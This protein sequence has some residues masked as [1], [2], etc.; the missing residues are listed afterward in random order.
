MVK[1]AMI[2]AAGVGSRLDPLTKNTPKPLVPIA[3]RPVMDLLL[4]KLSKVGIKKVIANTHCLA[5]QIQER[6]TNKN[7]FGI[8]FNHIFEETLSGTAGGVKKCE[9]FFDKDETFIVMSADGLTSADIGKVI[10]SHKASGAIATIGLTEVPEKEVPNFGVVVTN[11]D[12]RIIEFQEKPSIKDAKS[13]LVNTGIYVFESKI[14]EYMPKDSFYDFAKNV[15]PDLMSKNIPINTCVIKEYWSDIGTINQY[16]M[17]TNDV[18]EG[19]LNVE[20]GYIQNESSRIAANALM[21]NAKVTNS[22][23]GSNTCIAGDNVVVQKSVLGKNC[24]IN[25]DVKLNNCI[26]WDNVTIEEN[27]HLENCIIANDVLIKKHSKI[28]EGSVIGAFQIIGNNL[29][30]Q[31]D[32]FIK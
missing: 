1:K 28:D 6:Y 17:S 9:F 10:Q 3:N 27:V 30:K 23:I 16:R 22:I 8:E 26:I 21:G 19:I 4:E 14:F 11:K 5:E 32:A 20:T 29:M 18:L 7:L 13:N 2:M 24:V 25:K 12:N 31:E 15:F